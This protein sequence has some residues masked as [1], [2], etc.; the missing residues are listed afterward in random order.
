MITWDEKAHMK[1]LFAIIST[2]A[3]KVDHQA[4]ANIM[5]NGCTAIAIQRRLARIKTMVTNSNS[6]AP[7]TPKSKSSGKKATKKRAAEKNP[8]EEFG[9]AKKVKKEHVEESESEE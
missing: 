8:D 3:L 5:G 7:T 1:L 4:V 6:E 9:D 2:S